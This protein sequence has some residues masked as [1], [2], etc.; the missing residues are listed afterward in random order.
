MAGFAVTLYG[1]FW[2]SAEAIAG[3]DAF[4]I[5]ALMGHR[6]MKTTERYIRAHRLTRQVAL[7]E[8]NVHKLATNEIR[9]PMLAAVS[10]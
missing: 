1:R 4:T 7:V 5:K 2:V 6:D 3:Y 10:R 8:K 9:P